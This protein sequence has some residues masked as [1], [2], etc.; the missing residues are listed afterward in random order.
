[1]RGWPEEWPDQG[2]KGHFLIQAP[3]WLLDE[4]VRVTLFPTMRALIAAEDVEFVEFEYD[5]DEIRLTEEERNKI[6]ESQKVLI[7][8]NKAAEAKK[9]HESSPLLG[10]GTTEKQE[11]SHD[12]RGIKAAE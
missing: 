11:A 3:E 5:S 9:E 8:L 6:F 2:G 1:M 7:Q 12:E 10:D 4:G